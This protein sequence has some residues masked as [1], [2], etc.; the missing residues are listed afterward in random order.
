VKKPSTRQPFVKSGTYEG[1][2]RQKSRQRASVWA[3]GGARNSS[4]ARCRWSEICRTR[5]RRTG[6]PRSGGEVGFGAGD[7]LCL[8]LETGGIECIEMRACFGA[9]SGRFLAALAGRAMLLAVCCFAAGK[10]A[11]EVTLMVGPNVN[12]TR[13]TNNNAEECIAINPTNP[14]NLFASDTWTVASR[15]SVDGGITWKDSDVSAL[16]PSRGDVSAVFDNF[17]NLFLAR[18]VGGGAQSA[19]G[20]SVDSGATFAL[21]YQSSGLSGADEPIV[22][23]GPSATPGEGRVWFAYSLGTLVVRGA[24]VGGLGGV[25]ARVGRSKSSSLGY[26]A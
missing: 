13:S 19:V 25:S 17:G 11:G 4:S 24:E 21:L 23:A 2:S 5:P 16:P 22:D 12:I 7:S 18:F 14:K 3:S 10:A 20:L 9:G 15:Y 6:V 26:P 1:W 8:M